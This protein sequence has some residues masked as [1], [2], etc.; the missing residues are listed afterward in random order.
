LEEVFRRHALGGDIPSY[1]R[2]ARAA[3]VMM[4]PIP[5][6]GRLERVHGI[7]DATAVASVEEVAITAHVGQELIPLPEGW[8]YL[9]FIFARADTPDGVEK[10]LR[11]AHAHLPF[12]I[13]CPHS[14]SPA[15]HLSPPGSLPGGRPALPGP[16]DFGLTHGSRAIRRAGLHGPRARGLRLLGGGSQG[17]LRH[18]CPRSRSLCDRDVHSQ[19][20]R[21]RRPR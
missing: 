14:D 7:E 2:E 3:G 5:R 16:A 1:D 20:R 4:I 15:D 18:V 19:S 10:A 6:A 12:T 8:Q 21:E 17:R 13:A 11:A 9:G